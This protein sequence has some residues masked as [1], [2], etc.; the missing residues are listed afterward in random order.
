MVSHTAHVSSTETIHSHQIFEPYSAFWMAAS[1]WS[2][3]YA[4]WMDGT[5]TNL[6]PEEVPL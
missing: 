6:D 1:E 5:F 4:T 3:N 2:T